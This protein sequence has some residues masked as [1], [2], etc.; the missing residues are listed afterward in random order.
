MSGEPD[1]PLR[2]STPSRR[3]RAKREADSAA[4]LSLN[5]QA[6]GNIS[7]NCRSVQDDV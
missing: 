4:T 6:S 3:H 7:D 1:K 5:G 2:L